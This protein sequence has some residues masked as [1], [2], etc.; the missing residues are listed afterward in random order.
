M[1]TADAKLWM[2][3]DKS[4]PRRAIV[5]LVPLPLLLT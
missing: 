3:V 4:G 5:P 1:T 2:N